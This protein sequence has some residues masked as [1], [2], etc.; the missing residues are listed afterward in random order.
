MKKNN[1]K[2]WISWNIKNGLIGKILYK[3]FEFTFKLTKNEILW[4]YPDLEER[5]IK[6]IHNEIGNDVL[7]IFDYN[8]DIKNNIN[9]FYIK[10]N[11]KILYQ[12]CC[13]LIPNV[14]SGKVKDWSKIKGKYGKIDNI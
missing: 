14:F 13:I 8:N 12:H 9:V 10:N 4:R 11:Q 6:T 7:V 2:Y 1:W 3:V 5:Y